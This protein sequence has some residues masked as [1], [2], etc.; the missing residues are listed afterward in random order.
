MDC[1]RQW[2]FMN[3]H[4][5]I[6][7]FKRSARIN[8]NRSPS[9]LTVAICNLCIKSSNSRTKTTRTWPS[10]KFELANG[11][12]Q[13]QVKIDVIFRI[14]TYW[15]NQSNSNIYFVI[16]CIALDTYQVLL[17]PFFT[18]IY[19]HQKIFC[20]YCLLR[21]APPYMPLIYCAMMQ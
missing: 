15:I 5:P 16:L 17:K 14:F 20:Q 8:N 11:F 19:L 18:G 12:S 1:Q 9:A 21:I 13:A 3:R 4:W 10:L 7:F 2:Y 6:L